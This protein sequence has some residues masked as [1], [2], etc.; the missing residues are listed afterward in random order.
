L[1]LGAGALVTGALSCFKTSVTPTAGAGSLSL[2]GEE[3]A[4]QRASGPLQVA[5]ATP[6]GEVGIVTEV[7]VVFDRPVQPLGVVS[8]GPAPF[9]I[10]PEVPG[11][12]RWVGSRAAVF[13]PERRLALATAYSV[14]VPAGLQALD[15][16]RLEQPYRFQLETSRPKL[17]RFSPDGERNVKPDVELRLELNQEVSAA[18]LREAGELSVVGARGRLPFEV[19]AAQ[20]QRHVLLVRAKR[21]L[22]PHSDIAFV[23]QPSLRGV[24][25]P[26]ATG[27]EQ[28]IKFRTYDPLAIT[29]LSCSRESPASDCDPESGVSLVL[30]NGVKPKDLAAK[31][32]VTPDPGL[33]WPAPNS[34]EAGSPTTYVGLIGR[35][36]AGQS[37]SV[38]VEAGLVDEFG[39][40]TQ[41]P[42]SVGFRVKDH[43]PRVDI[44][45]VG[46]NFPGRDLGVPIASRNVASF[47]LLTAALSPAELTA[48]QALE[49]RDKDQL[50]WL[51]RLG[52]TQVQRV[53]PRGAKNRIEQ[54]LLDTSKV[55]GNGGR[56]ALAIAAR[57]APARGDWAAPDAMKV[58]NLSDLAIAAKLSRFGSL[59]WVT[60]RASNAAVAGAEV[61]L[62][63]DGRPQRKY[64]TDSDGLAAIPAADFAPDLESR[65]PES[66]AILVARRGTDSAF[67]AVSEHIDSWRLD[68]PSDFSG[69]LLPYG[70]A[71]TDRGIYR[72]GD[73]VWVKGIVRKQAVSGN[74]LPGEQPL[75]VKLISPSGDEVAKEQALLTAHGSFATKLRVPAG[76]ELGSYSVSVSGLSRERFLEQSLEVAEY[77]PV[78]MKVEA[79]ADRPSYVRGDQA[80]L[81]VRGSFLFGAPVSDGKVL[82]G[83]AHQPTWFQVPGAEAFATDA[84]TYYSE[85]DEVSGYGEFRREERKLDAQGLQR[86]TEKLDLPAQRGTELLRIDAEVSDV[87]RR[88]VATSSTALIHPAT[89]YVGLKTAGESSLVS[90]P[91]RLEARVAAFEPGGK[92]L[93]GKRVTLE[94]IE[95]RY[96]FAKEASGDGYRALSKRVDKSVG[97][98][99][100]VTRTSSSATDEGL[101]SCPLSVP[102]AGYYVL[103]AR[104]KDER[105]NATEAA[106]AI[107]ATG[108]GEPTWQDDDRRSL[109][110]VLDK[111]SYAVGE[112]AKVLVK[113]PYQEAEALITVER[114][115]VYRAFRR[116]LRGGAPSFEVEVT[117]EMLPN[118]FVGVQ[119]LPR[120]AKGKAVLE[121]GSYRI[122]Y[123]SLQVDAAAR[124][125]SVGIAPRQRDLRPGQTLE[126]ALQVKD[127]QGRAASNTEL[128]FYAADEGVL[129]LI[130]YRTPDP[131][132]TF[133]SPRPLQVAT[134]ESRDLEG[135]IQLTALGNGADKGRDGGGGGESGLRRDF[136]QTAYFNPRV[137]TDARGEAKVSFK[138]P[139]SLTTYR[140]MAVAVGQSERYGFAEDRVTTSKPLMARP[141][142][143]RFV[144]VGDGLE[145]GIVV[146]K[147]SMAAGKVRVSAAA[148]GLVLDGAAEREVEV[149]AGGSLEVRFPARAPSAGS[150]RVRFA[151]EGGAERDGAEQVLQVGLP[152][153]LE[154]A[155]IYGTTRGAQ[156]ERL[157]E[158]GAAR[159]DVG[160]LTATLSS[161]ALVGLDQTA[162]ELIEYPYACTEQL[163]SRLLPLVALGDLGRALG[164]ALPA[165][166]KQRAE[167]ALGEVLARQQG[168]G[169]FAMWPES[170]GSVEWVSPWVTLALS[171][172]GK[173]GLTVPKAALERAREYL[174]ARVNAPSPSSAELGL[175]ALE[176]DVLGEL[177]A[178]DPG[179]VNRLFARRAE[180]PLFGKALLLHAA[181][182]AKLASDVP[183][184]LTR[185]LEQSLH[186]SGDGARV[187]DDAAGRFEAWLD[188]P[189]RTQAMVLRALAAQ[190]RH[191]L[192]TEVAR[193]LLSERKHGSFRTTQ[194]GAWALLALD[195]YRRVAETE[196]PDF[197]ATVRLGDR[198]LGSASFEKAS[199]NAQRVT[200]PLAALA[201][202]P[203]AP[204]V[205]EKEG[206]GQLFYEAR[207]RYARRELPRTPLDA[208]FYVEKS[209]RA[210]DP[211]VLG[212]TGA[213]VPA[214]LGVAEAV[215][216]GALVLVDVTVVVPA[217]RDFVVIDDPLPA[218]LE[219]QDPRL[220]TSGD[221]LALSGRSSEVECEGCSDERE[222]RGFDRSEVRDDR[223]LFFADRLP[224]GLYH[225]R[226]MARA[227]TLGRFVLPPTR[228]EEMYSPE[229]FGRT[230]T[231]E[232]SVR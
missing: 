19:T 188:S 102:A 86:W 111:S 201:A 54:L 38:Q 27:V 207:L 186:V 11:R 84:S 90:A 58:L 122:G 28:R 149:P 45:A 135:R 110:L 44:G 35:F 168:D 108:D 95:R 139:D 184:E 42:L 131:L 129:S 133:A 193:G 159:S 212:K 148:T 180:L 221:F 145:L 17:L 64:L 13:T 9:R 31:L 20:N 147:K 7:S 144:R 128:T 62:V 179:G 142:L 138:L 157:G 92:R 34:D 51:S 161:T 197:R 33:K 67:V 72:P 43:F 185:E 195:D 231:T 219:A 171:R 191:P 177:G 60:D 124:R 1:W 30:S 209:L 224:A 169:G 217:P 50:D 155:A 41:K 5:L 49:S 82:L 187:K 21:P 166:S 96:T 71:F 70:V 78:E 202:Q 53:T 173:A 132:L 63:V 208:G 8:E 211:L 99:E 123:A 39:Q 3:A 29:E 127:A 114:S 216:A 75:Q 88:T 134:L 220:L 198:R 176:L 14:E 152:M 16:T 47:D 121:P 151:V 119:L 154:T 15:G 232:V 25:G 196:A 210:V 107:Y 215:P 156:S 160:E 225:Y 228:A 113:S 79:E 85:I 214:S 46:R 223:V 165:D 36:Q 94:L 56:G 175:V 227:T 190:G 200:L 130:G 18:A 194:E 98:C 10:S 118:A 32:R 93:A 206:S 140:L 59:A 65:S 4:G 158:L 117:P 80:K 163:A 183:E 89:F 68:V 26:L 150:A 24:E 37:Y 69:A 48:W 192:L 74:A 153:P 57:Y 162:L 170:G 125:L 167:A 76:R 222:S 12:F 77:R 204:L 230:G 199:T 120:R 101:A 87:S 126:V 181:L 203:A 2:R 164:F 97:K 182:G 104:S 229:T 61:T 115:G 205:F 189:A 141:A 103:L 23:I 218:G 40:V 174:R 109:S 22:P 172:A 136:R 106:R 112:R 55:L 83:V 178:A 91:G 213:R 143:P 116:T 226:Y 105:G 100:T 66:R 52:H 81:E 6:Q 73:E 146:S 137:I